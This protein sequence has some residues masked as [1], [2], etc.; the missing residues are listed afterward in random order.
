MKIAKVNDFVRS[1]FL[2]VEDLQDERNHKLLNY[3]FNHTVELKG[4]Q[5]RDK[6]AGRDCSIKALLMKQKELVAIA[7]YAKARLALD[8]RFGW[9]AEAL[10]LGDSATEVL[11]LPKTGGRYLFRRRERP[12]HN[13][14][15][16][17]K[18]V[19]TGNPSYFMPVTNYLNNRF[20]VC[21]GFHRYLHFRA[22]GKLTLAET[23]TM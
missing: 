3:I 20:W 1:S 18:H 2:E 14:I 4:M 22:N 13:G 15:Y 7:K 19:K 5:E 17:Y 12:L 21:H 8:V 11:H 10:Q 9:I 23:F 16:D 6:R